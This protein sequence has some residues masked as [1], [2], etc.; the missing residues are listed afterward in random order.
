MR[1][2]FG[3]AIGAAAMILATVA[4][5]QTPAPPPQ[6]RGQ[7][8]DLGRP[9]KNDDQVP[10]FDFD[11]Y[12][13]GTW[14]F[15]WDVPEGPLGPAGRLEGTTVYTSLGGGAYQAITDA[16]GPA[17]KF[18]IKE[19]IRYQKEQKTLT[20]DVT[21][22]R[23]FSYSQKGTIGGDLGGFFNIY[24]ESGPFTA[25]GESVRM[26]HGLRLTSPLS[27][28]LSASVSIENGPF[29]NYGTPWWRKMAPAP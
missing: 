7:T 13:L 28:R 21:D 11:A 18:T 20:R 14:T 12:F 23:G 8:Q 5:A 3:A 9:T 25:G 22:S 26:K 6:P 15:E 2:E 10:T 1:R 29:S 16:S 4:F 19:V 17:G 24:F 27:Y